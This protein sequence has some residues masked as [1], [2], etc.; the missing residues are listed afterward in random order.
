MTYS[1]IR[2][3]VVSGL[4]GMLLGMFLLL[5]SRANIEGLREM[6]GIAVYTGVAG[7]LFWGALIGLALAL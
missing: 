6:P 3:V 5:I 4:S 2:F 1:A 7:A